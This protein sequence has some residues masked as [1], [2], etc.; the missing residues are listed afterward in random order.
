MV[1]DHQYDLGLMLT[2]LPLCLLARAANIFPLATFVNSKR[3]HKITFNMQVMQWACG[4]RGAIAYALAINMPRGPQPESRAFETATLM[5]VVVTTLVLG[6]ATGPLL[7][8]LDLKQRAG[9]GST[10]AAPDGSMYQPLTEPRLNDPLHP[11]HGDDGHPL[12]GGDHLD[13][14]LLS[15]LTSQDMS[16][17]GIHKVWKRLDRHLVRILRR[18][19][20]RAEH[21]QGAVAAQSGGGGVGRDTW[22]PSDRSAQR[23]MDDRADF[24]V[25]APPAPP[26]GSTA[27]SAVLLA[28][29]G[30]AASNGDNKG[31]G[32]DT[33][34]RLMGAVAMEE[35]PPAYEGVAL[36]GIEDDNE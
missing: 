5:I 25:Q 34:P 30:A 24:R 31:G 14:G 7:V 11:H 15:P 3:R 35:F 36:D 27:A 20:W 12:G 28:R 10:A 9:G 32:A 19:D 33:N 1:L 6:G 13:D 26:F 8:L 23:Q 17:E 29:G 4:L 22:R 2:G 18:E 16:Y 21:Q